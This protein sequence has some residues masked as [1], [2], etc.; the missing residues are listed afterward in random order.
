[1]CSSPR[2]VLLFFGI[3]I[4]IL[5]ILYSTGCL[6]SLRMRFNIY[7][8][9]TI[10]RTHNMHAVISM[11]FRMMRATAAPHIPL[12]SYSAQCVFDG[13]D[14]YSHRQ[15]STW[16]RT[17]VDGARTHNKCQWLS[18]CASATLSDIM[19]FIFFFILFKN[20]SNR[21]TIYAFTAVVCRCTDA[22]DMPH[23][24][25]IAQTGRRTTRAPPFTRVEH[26]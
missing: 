16:S 11:G 26:V 24:V 8:R 22:N 9:F 17:A 5:F 3:F 14:S 1:M 4:C 21:I 2:I 23:R 7:A 19:Y 6:P 18:V 20:P 15:A 10:R 12:P 25:G 13:V